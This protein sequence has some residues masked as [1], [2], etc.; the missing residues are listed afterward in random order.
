[1]QKTRVILI[2]IVGISFIAV[3]LL[4]YLS[5]EP[6]L[7]AVFVRANYPT[8]FY[9]I[10]GGVEMLG[11]ILVL[12]TASATKRLGSALIG[13]VM[14]GALVTRYL[15]HEPPIRFIMPGIILVIAILIS[16]DFGMKKEV[17][18]ETFRN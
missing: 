11:G 1:M 12:M 5:L 18:G 14:L 2:W 15:L 10:I 8:W 7:K 17:V 3:G 4:K 6:E 9:Y 13:V 16:F